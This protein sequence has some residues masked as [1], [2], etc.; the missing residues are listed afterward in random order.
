MILKQFCYDCHAEGANK[1]SIAFDE[2]A[3]DEALLENHELWSKALKNVRAGMMP[4]EKKPQPSTEQKE[5]HYVDNQF[6]TINAGW[7]QG[8]WTGVGPARI[9]PRGRTGSSLRIRV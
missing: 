2:F 4:P 3:S 6:I 7:F 5:R 9:Y 1:G 8:R